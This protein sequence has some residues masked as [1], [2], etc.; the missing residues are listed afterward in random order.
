MRDLTVSVVPCTH[1]TEVDTS[2]EQTRLPLRWSQAPAVGREGKM[3][4]QSTSDLPLQVFCGICICQFTSFK[5]TRCSQDQKF[6]QTIFQLITRKH[7]NIFRASRK[8][9]SAPCL[10]AGA[11]SIPIVPSPLSFALA[12]PF[13]GLTTVSGAQCKTVW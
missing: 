12:R 10:P 4:K 13:L 2:Q 11:S 8:G 3:S 1:S 9:S 6:K 5:R 7:Y